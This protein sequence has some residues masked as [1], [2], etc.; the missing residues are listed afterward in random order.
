VQPVVVSS[1]SNLILR[2]PMAAVR[3]AVGRH[4]SDASLEGPR[5]G[6]RAGAR[7]RTKLRA[8]ARAATAGV[9]AIVVILSGSA[10]WVTSLSERDAHFV[11]EELRES[12][13]Y[14]EAH[15]VL[16]DEHRLQAT[17]IAVPTQ[18]TRHAFDDAARRFVAEID[19]ARALS[20][21]DG[22]EAA[23]AQRGLHA[24]SNYVARARQVFDAVDRAD[25]PAIPPLVAAADDQFEPLEV[26]LNDASIAFAGQA[27]AAARSLRRSATTV[28]T[29]LPLLVG[30][31][32]VVIVVGWLVMRAYRRLE[33]QTAARFESLVDH[34]ADIIMVLNAEQGIS[35]V[36][37][38]CRR[39]LGYDPEELMAIPRGE[40]IHADD[41]PIFIIARERCSREAG[42]VVGPIPIR[43]RHRDETWR[44][45][46]V[47]LSNHLA[48]PA[49]RG[50]VVNAHD[51]T[52]LKAA[53]ADLAHG[54]THDGLTGLPNRALF[55]DRLEVLATRSARRP[56]SLALLFCDLDG[57]KVINDSLGHAAGDSVL[58][59]V[60]DRLGVAVRPG[61][62]IA[63]FGGDEFVISCEGV[64]DEQEARVIAARVTKALAPA[65]LVDGK[66]VY[67]GVSVGIRLEK[68]TTATALESLV[69]DA[70]A[71]MYHAKREGRGG[72]VVFTEPLREHTQRRLDLESGLH[73]ALE[74]GEFRLHYQPTISLA[75]GRARGFEALVRW[76]HPQRG[77]VFPADFIPVAEETGLIVPLG[78]WVLER[79]CRQL[80]EWQARTTTP[81]TMAV[82]LSARQLNDP[83]LVAQV[84]A[85]LERTAVDPA[86]VCLEVTESAVMADVEAS[87]AT[88]ESLKRLGVALAI[89]DFGTGYSSLSYL[90]RFPIDILKI[91]RGFVAELGQQGEATAIVASVI[92][93][94]QA[95]ALQTIAEGVETAEQRKHLSNLGCDI[96]QGYLWARP[97]PAETMAQWLDAPPAPGA[98][99]ATRGYRVLIA[100]DLPE[101]RAMVRR[102]LERSKHFDVVGEAEDGQKAI[103]LA[104][105]THPDLVLLDLS[106]PNMGG[107][108]A[109]PAILATTK[110][111]KVVLLSGKIIEEGQEPVPD[112]AAAY[113]GKMTTPARL[114]DELLTVMRAT[115]SAA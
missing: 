23:A 24:H 55:I 44:W 20:G 113:L 115:E 12:T 63:R 88:L 25:T 3:S 41:L 114:I 18:A 36:T 62:T 49:V 101:H 30:A 54:A 48:N 100:D 89:D 37:P 11:D 66:D 107:L 28:R 5:G 51:V 75:D 60:A 13:H 32:L 52:E 39:T 78:A 110:H 57:F 22:A 10:L 34:S 102:I 84:A 108:Q 27:E 43:L 91:D 68:I 83:D 56:I 26:E 58:K 14:A 35:F 105:Q 1:R 81:I 21:D 96:G 85:I 79:A 99:G 45:L 82:N 109:L 4:R 95:L 70:D 53:E 80:R 94:A 64:S 86:A 97:A 71:A 38:A 87:V 47:S 77:L 76:E 90:Q 61:D 92:H 67:V 59:T 73:R 17:Y 65:I 16:F 9:V 31:S 72:V 6:V 104:A 93:L 42:M 40:L 7:R 46:Q 8:A 111:T 98:T 69:A 103:D 33:E 2:R 74:R 112:G 29:V 19:A 50:F 106:M 15:R